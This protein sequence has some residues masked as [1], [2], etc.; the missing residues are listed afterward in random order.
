MTGPNPTP[1]LT[2]VCGPMFSGKSSYLVRAMQHAVRQGREV[3]LLRPELDTRTEDFCTHDGVRA[4]EGVRTIVVPRF[5][6]LQPC[7][8]LAAQ[9]H[10]C[11]LVAVDEGHMYQPAI[12]DWCDAWRASYEVIVAGCDMDYLSNPFEGMARLLA[13]CDVPHKLK[14]VCQVCRGAAAFTHRTQDV[15]GPRLRVGGASDYEARCLAHRI[16]SRPALE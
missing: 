11:A 7:L 6:Q 10:P 15:P 4:P 5:F 3:V 9:V 8:E 2:V 16:A 12:A 13:Y 1:G 14:A